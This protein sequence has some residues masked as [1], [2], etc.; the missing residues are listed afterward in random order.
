[1]RLLLIDTCGEGASLAL[2]EDASVVASATTPARSASAALLD[3][4]TALLSEPGWKL[5]QLHAIGVV[6]GP[7]S[8]TGVR[9]GLSCAKGLCEAL[10]IPLAAVSRLQALAT[11]AALSNGYAIL[12]A[13]RGEVFVLDVTTG[14][15]TIQTI[16]SFLKTTRGSRIVVAEASLLEKFG[17]PAAELHELHASAALPLVLNR[18]SGGGDDVAEIDA[19][20]LRG[21]Q[22]IYGRSSTPASTAQ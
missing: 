12:N 8:F 9:V 17:A 20:Y 22:Q 15:E 5:R 14:K 6:N 18:F 4:V 1:M 16:D 2:A 11:A 13:G 19:N 3:T 10:S 21:E 7:G